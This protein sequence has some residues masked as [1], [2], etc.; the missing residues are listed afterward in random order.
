MSKITCIHIDDETR[1]LDM[2]G[3]ILKD[4]PSFEY[5]G[6]FQ[7]TAEAYEVIRSKHIDIIFLDILLDGENGVDFAM[8]LTDMP[9]SVVF[10]TSHTDFAVR[11]FQACA[12]H[13]LVKPVLRSDL[14]LLVDQ[15][16]TMRAKH[17]ALLKQLQLEELSIHQKQQ[18]IPP[19]RI[20]IHAVKEI[21]VVD[22]SEVIFMKSV[23]RYT[24]FIMKDGAKHVSSKHLKFYDEYIEAHNDFVRI[25]RSAIVNKNFVKKIISD[26]K[27][28]ILLLE[29]SNGAQLEVSKAR[30]DHIINDFS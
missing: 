24:H 19:R 13:F 11:A 18:G 25:H 20:F 12:L 22:L 14:D 26:S 28:N 9:V 8:Q 23:D 30:K 7:N 16:K 27:K 2:L 10:V 6:G 5:L 29:M 3:A 4:H 17:D 21:I 15:L 1:H